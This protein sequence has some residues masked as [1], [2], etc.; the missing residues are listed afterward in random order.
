MTYLQTPTIAL[1][2]F[3]TPPPSPRLQEATMNLADF[4][5]EA[6]VMKDMMHPNLVQLLG[7]CT[8][9]PPFYIITE[10]M[11]NGNLLDFQVNCPTA[12]F[13]PNPTP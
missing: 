6:T 5:D 9:E 1:T 8:R 12:T 4:L 2:Y 10:F 7:V 11:S 3:F 13:S